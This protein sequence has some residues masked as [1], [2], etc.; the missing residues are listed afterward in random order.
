MQ[1]DDRIAT[2]ERYRKRWQEFGYDPRTLGWNKDCQWVRFEAAFDG[3]RPDEQE[4]V[5]DL[6]CGFGD[7][8]GFLRARG[9]QGRYTGVDLVDELIGE[10]RRRHA[11][12]PG[13][14][15]V[16]GDLESVALTHRHDMAGAIGIFNHR[17]SDNLRFVRETIDR[18]WNATDKVVVCD[19]LSNTA[20]PDRRQDNLYYADAG[21]LYAL[22][23]ERSRRVMVH[24]AYMPFEF[25]VKLWH[26]DSFEVPAPVFGPYRHLAKAQSE[27]LGGASSRPADPPTRPEP[28]C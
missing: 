26:D 1:A 10:A 28:S 19:F 5:L 22:A 18:M 11:G 16:S 6:G 20:D 17:I 4:S 25:Q 2:Q 15:F 24:H 14:S 23:A 9:W 12:D 13:A 27:R 8:L 3:I 21:D 7:L